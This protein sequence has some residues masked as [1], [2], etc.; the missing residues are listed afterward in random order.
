MKNKDLKC[1]ECKDSDSENI[2]NYNNILYYL[3]DDCYREH[4]KESEEE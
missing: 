1:D 2:L 4:M 3:C